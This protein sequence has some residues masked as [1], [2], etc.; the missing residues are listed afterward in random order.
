MSRRNVQNADVAHSHFL[1]DEVN[2]ELHM[3]GPAMVNRILGEADS[4]D[5]VAVDDGGF[6]HWNMKLAK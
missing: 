2:I 4:R 6:V 3:L 5:V 1:T